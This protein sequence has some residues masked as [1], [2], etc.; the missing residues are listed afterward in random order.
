[1]CIQDLVVRM[2]LKNVTSKVI[3]LSDDTRVDSV[4]TA[5]GRQWMKEAIYVSTSEH[6]TLDIVSA[7]CIFLKTILYS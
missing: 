5:I 4:L 3:F 7:V 6:K 2:S 1:M